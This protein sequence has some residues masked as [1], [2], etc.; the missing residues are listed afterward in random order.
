MVGVA[1][2]FSGGKVQLNR[3]FGNAGAVVVDVVAVVAVDDDDD[4]DDVAAC[5]LVLVE[6]S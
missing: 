1:E 4:E 2:N 3:A 5:I 6:I